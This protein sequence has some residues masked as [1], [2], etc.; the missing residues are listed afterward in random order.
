MPRRT[1]TLPAGGSTLALSLRR[2]ANRNYKFSY[3][4]TNKISFG[5]ASAAPAESK[6]SEEDFDLFGEDTEEDLGKLLKI[7]LLFKHI[8]FGVCV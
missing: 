7:L 1:L 8:F 2:S 3:L 4:E 6:K 5:G